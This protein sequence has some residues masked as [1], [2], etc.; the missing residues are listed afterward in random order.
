[1]HPKGCSKAEDG[2]DKAQRMILLRE[3]W[4]QDRGKSFVGTVAFRTA[5][6][7]AQS[8]DTDN[9]KGIVQASRRRSWSTPHRSIGTAEPC[10]NHVPC[11]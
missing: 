6:P 8:I 10:A 4:Q 3:E 7:S 11:R 5:G 1:M 9:D 2:A